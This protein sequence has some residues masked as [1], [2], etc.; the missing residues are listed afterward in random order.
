MVFRQ[1]NSGSLEYNGTPIL[2]VNAPI[3]FNKP[4]WIYPQ[5]SPDQ[6]G[7]QESPIVIP[8]GQAGANL[9]C[10]MVYFD[11]GTCGPTGSWAS[12]NALRIEIQ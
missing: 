12:S 7:F 2:G 3:N 4:F 5:P 10:Q 11:P 6:Y 1:S 8:A 9:F